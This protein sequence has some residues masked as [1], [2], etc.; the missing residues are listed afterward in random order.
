M[1]QHIVQRSLG[2][3]HG[4]ATAHIDQAAQNIAFDAVIHHH[5][6][7]LGRRCRLLPTRLGPLEHLFGG[8]LL[9][10]VQPSQPRKRTRALDGQLG[11]I[12]I[13]DN[14]PTLGALIPKDSREPAGIDFRDPHHPQ[15]LQISR[16][17]FR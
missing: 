17:R 3:H 6:V 14:T 13:G 5:D 2:R 1:G 16:Q 15:S 9:S 7:M 4:D 12:R 8:D 10:E 11:I